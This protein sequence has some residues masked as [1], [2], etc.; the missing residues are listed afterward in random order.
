MPFMLKTCL[1]SVIR[2]LTKKIEFPVSLFPFTS[3]NFRFSINAIWLLLISNRLGYSMFLRNSIIWCYSMWL[4]TSIWFLC[5]V[6]HGWSEIKEKDK[7]FWFYSFA[8]AYD[9]CYQ[10]CHWPALLNY[11]RTWNRRC[12][13]SNWW[14]LHNTPSRIVVL[15]IEPD[16][17]TW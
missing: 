11:F 8:V 3:P 4:S 5:K 7:A 17:I 9:L 1:Y 15:W 14:H 10:V 12:E 16:I 13:A 2:V 6:N